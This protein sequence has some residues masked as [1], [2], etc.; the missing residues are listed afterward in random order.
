MKGK[1]IIT[2]VLIVG[3]CVAAASY[4]RYE[5]IRD[6]VVSADVECDPNVESCFEAV[7]EGETFFY[8]IVRKPAT[9]IPACDPWSD[10]CEELSCVEGEAGCYIENCNSPSDSCSGPS[11]LDFQ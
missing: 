8:K 1:H 7:Y 4:Y 6:Y 5:V 9:L 3:L 2:A 11:A 10:E